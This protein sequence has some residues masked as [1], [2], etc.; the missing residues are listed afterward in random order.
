MTKN[1]VSFKEDV[2]QD[3]SI[4]DKIMKEFRCGT[5][6][7]IRPTKA[8]KMSN[9]ELYKENGTIPVISN[10]SMNNG[11]GGYSDLEPTEK[12][13]IIT[14]SDTTTGPDTLF[15]QPN[16]FIGYS[17]V[18]GMYPF[19]KENWNEH[20]LMYYICALKRA[21]GTSWNYANKFNRKLVAEIKAL[22]PIIVDNENN[23]ILDEECKYHED[24]YIPDFNYMK[25]KIV[26]LE[27]EIIKDIELEKTTEIEQYF[28]ITGLKE[29]TLLEEDKSIMNFLMN[30]K[31]DN[32]LE[33]QIEEFEISNLFSLK[34]IT[35]KLSQQDLSDSYKYPAYS[36]NTENNGI[37]GYTNTPEFTCNEECPVYLTFGDHTRTLNIVRESFGVLD[38]VKVL[39]PC[40]DNDEAL[41]YI[42]T[43][44]KKQIPNLG[45]AR[46]W[47]IAKDCILS[48]PIKLDSNKKPIIDKE[49]KYH[50][51]GYI[52][53]WDFMK[54]CIKTIEKLVILDK[55]NHKENL[56]EQMKMVINK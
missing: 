41:L 45:Y 40:I 42:I 39:V 54:R 38:N 10:S 49:C 51:D 4:N 16:D 17:H 34:K 48:L 32:N 6:F 31:R 53:D 25:E 21:S 55:I 14:F 36:S 26:S 7:D 22:L 46:H 5:L 47:K 50:N 27:E 11:I 33:I 29:C 2:T 43:Q 3:K 1:N 20:T 24:G 44:W 9:K 35:Q 28:N 19:Y 30:N 15:Y 13:G 56:I 23:P 18:Q 37:I 12:G 52:P 8:Y